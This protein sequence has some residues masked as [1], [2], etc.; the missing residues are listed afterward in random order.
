MPGKR[1]ATNIA[2]M[3]VLTEK[4]MPAR[5]LCMPRIAFG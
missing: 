1:E 2:A 3:V 4:L 5:I